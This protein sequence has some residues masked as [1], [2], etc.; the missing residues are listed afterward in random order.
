MQAH[1]VG[2]QGLV[3]W[4]SLKP[5]G[6]IAM[7]GQ[8]Y[9][10]TEIGILNLTKRLIEVAVEDREHGDCEV[11]FFKDAKINDRPC[12]RIEV[13]HP[14]RE[15]YFRFYKALVFI[16]DKLNIP[17][18]YEAYDWPTAAGEKP[19]LLEQYTY[20][21]VKLNNGFTDADFEPK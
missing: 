8:R 19:P 13:I 2:L 4:V 6:P 10:I 16:D 17:V 18:R 9:P 7:R 15:S 12:T 11:K 5:D 21:D 14:T 3:G 1:G 20:I